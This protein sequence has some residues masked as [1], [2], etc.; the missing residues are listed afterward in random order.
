MQFDPPQDLLGIGGG[1]VVGCQ[2]SLLQHRE[3]VLRVKSLAVGTAAVGLA[4][5]ALG[6]DC[7]SC[8]AEWHDRSAGVRVVL[9]SQMAAVSDLGRNLEQGLWH[10]QRLVNGRRR[11]SLQKYEA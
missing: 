11:H 3:L 1:D 8:A 5:G 2:L 9:G 7:D 6:L 4:T 10:R